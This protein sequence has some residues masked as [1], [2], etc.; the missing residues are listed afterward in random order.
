MCEEMLLRVNDVANRL[1]LGRS[2]VYQRFIQTGLLPSV[3]IGGARRVV[4]S[5]LEDFVRQLR[6]DGG[7]HEE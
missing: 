7:H 1:R 2:F 4:A 6:R 5:D 3:K